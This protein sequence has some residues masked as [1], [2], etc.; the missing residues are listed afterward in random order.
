MEENWQNALFKKFAKVRAWETETPV[1]VG[2]PSPA[3]EARRFFL[4][5]KH[6][7]SEGSREARPKN[8]NC[9]ER[10]NFLQKD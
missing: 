2:P 1:R 6:H 10:R 8:S 9:V 5:D 3:R 7:S 4:K